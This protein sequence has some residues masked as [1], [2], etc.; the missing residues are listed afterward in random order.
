MRIRIERLFSTALCLALVFS[1]SPTAVAADEGELVPVSIYS[2]L[3]GFDQTYKLLLK[4]D[5][6]YISLDDAAKI[7]ASSSVDVG[8]DKITFIR[9]TVPV[10][11][12]KDE[13]TDFAGKLYLPLEAS[14]EKLGVIC[15]EKSGLLY[16]YSNTSV[17]EL[18]TLTSDVFGRF[19]ITAYDNFAGNAGIVLAKIWDV[20]VSS[21]WDG[22]I[23]QYDLDNYKELLVDLM[24]I[25]DSDESLL[26]TASELHSKF[27]GA[28]EKIKDTE[29]VL[30]Y[31]YK[32]KGISSLFVGPDADEVAQFF[33]TYADVAK[34]LRLSELF[35]AA[36]FSYGVQQATPVFVDA[37]D[38]TILKYDGYYG[39]NKDLR[40]AAQLLSDYHSDSTGGATAFFEQLDQ[41]MTKRVIKDVAEDMAGQSLKT[42]LSIEKTIFDAVFNMSKKAKAS[43]RA[44]LLVQLQHECFAIYHQ[45]KN[46]SDDPV[47][48]KYA[49]I[50]YLRAYKQLLK[51]VKFDKTLKRDSKPTI[52]LIDELISALTALSDDDL[53][54]E[55]KNTALSSEAVSRI[56]DSAFYTE[57]A[58][59][60]ERA[61]DRQ[62]YGSLLSGDFSYFAGKW[63]NLDG[64]TITLKN[65][66][67]VAKKDKLD[68]EVH[69]LSNGSY[70][71]TT[72]D[73]TYWDEPKVKNTSYWSLFPVG[74]E[75]MPEVSSDLTKIRIAWMGGG[76]S[77]APPA[78]NEIF[79]QE[80]PKIEP[81]LSDSK[82][83]KQLRDRLNADFGPFSDET[84]LT[85]SAGKRSTKT[86]QGEYIWYFDYIAV[87]ITS[88]SALV[89]ADAGPLSP[90]VIYFDYDT[91]QF[92]E[93][94]KYFDFDITK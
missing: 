40:A 17:D 52:K 4:Q 27:K 81:S 45:A 26:K 50:L 47:A 88:G 3:F 43:I 25:D 53:G 89:T 9:D 13:S 82:A 59:D 38:N 29:V 33:T 39:K 41:A 6:L 92:K 91:E 5:T 19:Q 14:L 23:M 77:Q 28:A 71:W 18:K 90:G 12:G 30:K 56:T 7:G 46:R 78:P 67:G 72:W 42:A 21:L 86:Y 75:I 20:A 87:R 8:A 31:I 94:N 1:L 83:T 64:D 36:E 15:I 16:L 49:A 48:M 80:R 34:G 93:F 35:A 51:D 85:I 62:T 57:L 60:L 55:V 10:E 66:G 84:P 69:K 73:G 74:V 24:R 32:E 63:T 61:A 76:T 68:G 2:N 11:F 22:S 54:R 44:E 79:Y 58:K 37:V 65:N 70:S